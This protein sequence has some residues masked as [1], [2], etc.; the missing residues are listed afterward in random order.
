MGKL[1]YNDKQYAGAVTPQPE[2]CPIGKIDMYA[3]PNAPN[4]WLL[5][6]GQAVSRTAYSDLFAVIGTTYGAGDGSTTFNLPDLRDRVPIG[7]G[8]SYLLND[9][10]GATS[11]YHTTGNV[12]LDIN[13]V[14]SHNHNIN[15]WFDLRGMDYAN[16]TPFP[17]V[18]SGL[19][20]SST[21]QSLDGF[22][23]AN[24]KANPRRLTIN[25]DTNSKGGGSAHNHGNTGD[26]SNMM[27]YRGI[28]FI[29][30]YGTTV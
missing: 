11:H 26:S 22:T 23:Q 3:G 24:T 14:P 19:S 4:G 5:C 6:R 29:I 12:T 7:V 1:L 30:Y 21:S 13:Q 10:G 20:V 25:K 15:T 18:G 8:S 27:P 17:N 9:Y 28:N 16:G 2:M